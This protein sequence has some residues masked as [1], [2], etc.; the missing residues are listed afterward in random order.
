[1]PTGLT[2]FVDVAPGFGVPPASALS[3]PPE[4]EEV[5][6]GAL[7]SPQAATSNGALKE[8]AIAR[9]ASVGLMASEADTR[10]GVWR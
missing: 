5:G 6:S 10:S 1:M 7:L 9:V 2:P 8:K 3:P 4:E